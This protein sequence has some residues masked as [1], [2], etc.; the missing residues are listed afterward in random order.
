VHKQFSRLNDFSE[1]WVLGEEAEAIVFVSSDEQYN[2]DHFNNYCDTTLNLERQLRKDGWA[3]V[4]EHDD[5]ET[6]G[7]IFLSVGH[8]PRKV[9]HKDFVL[10]VPRQDDGA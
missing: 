6:V 4:K 8:D 10:Y 7:F 3:G 5:L 9:I 2:D 1:M